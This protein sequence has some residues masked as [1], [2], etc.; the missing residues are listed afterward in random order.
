MKSRVREGE[1]GYVESQAEAHLGDG[2]AEEYDEGARHGS[3]G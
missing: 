1:K 2:E 3:R